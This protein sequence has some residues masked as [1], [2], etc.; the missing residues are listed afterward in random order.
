MSE[1]KRDYFAK[2]CRMCVLRNFVTTNKRLQLLSELQE[3][4]LIRLGQ[5]INE[6]TLVVVL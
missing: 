2:L 1:I 6:L 4:P 3:I 5:L